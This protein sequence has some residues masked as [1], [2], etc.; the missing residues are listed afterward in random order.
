MV[1]VVV[2]EVVCCCEDASVCGCCY[3]HFG[4]WGVCRLCRFAVVVRWSERVGDRDTALRG[5][6]LDLDFDWKGL[7]FD[8][9]SR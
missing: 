1:Q 5:Y 3:G 6:C 2:G 8:T 7:H 4:W 9:V